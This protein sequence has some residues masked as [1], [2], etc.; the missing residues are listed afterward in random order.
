M[1][2]NVWFQNMQ[3]N[4]LLSITF[5]MLNIYQPNLRCGNNKRLKVMIVLKKFSLY[6]LAGVA[7]STATSSS[8]LVQVSYNMLCDSLT[9]GVATVRGVPI[10]LFTDI[11]DTSTFSEIIC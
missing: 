6:L 4:S 1:S 8:L 3:T 10:P 9:V 11:S 5:R 2:L 7:T